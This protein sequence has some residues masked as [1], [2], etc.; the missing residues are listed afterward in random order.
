[1]RKQSR[2]EATIDNTIHRYIKYLVTISC[3]QKKDYIT[4]S[5]LDNIVQWLRTSIEHC[6]IDDFVYETSGKYKQLHCHFIMAVPYTFRY[7]AYTQWGDKDIT[8]NTFRIHWKKITHLSGAIKYINKDL[9]HQSQEEILFWNYY[10]INRFEDT[11]HILAP[12]KRDNMKTTTN[13]PERA[14]E[15]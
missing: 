6:A 12:S 9:Q 15:S 1:M 14:R 7:K 3:Q 11:K 4:P 2:S 10:S 5:A 13:R 8:I